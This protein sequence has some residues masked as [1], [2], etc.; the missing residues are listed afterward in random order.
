MI[1]YCAGVLIMIEWTHRKEQGDRNMPTSFGTILRR[2]RNEL[3]YNQETV[4]AFMESRG[5]PATKQA[6]SRWERGLNLPNAK[7]FLCLCAIYQVKDV[8]AVFGEERLSFDAS[9]LN[10]EGREKVETY[11]RDLVATGLYGIQSNIIPFRTR[12]PLYDLPASAGTGQF[13]DSNRY[14]M[15]D[16][17]DPL[18]QNANFGVRIAGDSMEPQFHDG[19]IVWVQQRPEIEPGEIGIFFLNGEA[20]IKMFEKSDDACRLVSLNPDYAPIEIGAGDDLRVFGKVL[21]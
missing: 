15:I 20:Y 19:E 16:T 1:F 8:C 4:A 21:Y 10:R 17:S 13:L 5:Y 14:E 3:G 12:R 11:I 2:L 7:Q 18:A 6:I 9:V